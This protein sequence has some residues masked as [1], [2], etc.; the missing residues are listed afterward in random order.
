MPR[1][2]LKG[3]DPFNYFGA[4]KRL[5]VSRD[6]GTGGFGLGLSIAQQISQW[7]GGDITITDSPLGG[8]SFTISWPEEKA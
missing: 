7:H 6:R 1:K 8:A 2:Q 5:D 4:F 3:S